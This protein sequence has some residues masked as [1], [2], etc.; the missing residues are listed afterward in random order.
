MEHFE[1]VCLRSYSQ[2]DRDEAINAFHQLTFPDFEKGLVDITL[3]R[4]VFL[5]SDLTI[6]IQWNSKILQKRKSSIGLQLAEAFSEF[7][8]IEHSM[9]VAELRVPLNVRRNNHEKHN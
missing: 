4:D 9:L 1:I 2:R 6:F 5:E 8:Y 3:L 7:G